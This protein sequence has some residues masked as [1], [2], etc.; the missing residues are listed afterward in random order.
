MRAVSLR[1]PSGRLL[2]TLIILITLMTLFPAC[3]TEPIAHQPDPPPEDPAPPQEPKGDPPVYLPSNLFVFTS[4]EDFGK[5]RHENTEV[6]SFGN[7]AVALKGGAAKGTYTSPEYGTDPFEYMIL[8]WN[9][10]TPR[11]TYI[12][13]EGRVYAGVGDNKEWSDWLPWGAWSTGPFIDETGKARLAGSAP[14]SKAGDAIA[15]VATDELYVKGS[16][17]ETA[18]RFQYRVT[19][20]GFEAASPKVALM[21]STIRNTLTGQAV[22]RVY[23]DNPPDLSKFDKDLDVP[24]YSQQQRYF[25]IAGSICS[26]TSVAMAVGYHGF[27]ISPDEMAWNV[28]DYVGDMFGNW[29]F[30]VAD[31]ASQ[32]MM[33]YVAYGDVKGDDSWYAVKQEISEGNPV[34]VSV[35]YRSPT[36]TANYPAV[37]NVPI[38]S[39]GGHLV[40]VR[41]FT[42]Q[43]GREYV[44][45][46]DSASAKDSEVRRLYPADQFASAWVK[47]VMYVIRPDENEIAEPCLQPHIQGN[48]VKVGDATDNGYQK[49][50]MQV[51]GSPVDL[52]TKTM[53]SAVVSFNGEKTTPHNPREAAMAESNYLWFRANSKSGKYTFW[54][55]DMNKNTYT[56]EIEW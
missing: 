45:V 51:D 7:G 39:T 30:N 29:S 56:A 5:G 47:K 55:F 4:V 42:W 53:R 48:L 50:E 46:N 27:D 43:D 10:D 19:L 35:K 12:E 33:A 22:S 26:P 3:A 34:V 31:A 13:I 36:S 15:H 38:N 40:L 8:S 17:G 18:D 11:G 16:S 2:A 37:E 21:A 25:K 14:S 23:P 9:A 54:F 24:M 44:I 52:S 28:N 49:Y 1:G 32:G 6:I 41:G 20:H